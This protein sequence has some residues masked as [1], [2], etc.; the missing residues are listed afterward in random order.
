MKEIELKVL[1]INVRT[2]EKKLVALGAKEILPLTLIRDKSYNSPDGLLNKRSELLRLRQE[3]KNVYLTYKY[4]TKNKRRFL[5]NQELEILVS[6]FKKID[7]T[8]LR[9][10]FT[11][12]SFREKKRQSYKLDKVRIEIDKYP[13]IPAYIELEGSAK[14]I[15]TLLKKLDIDIRHTYTYT[16]PEV[17]KHYK[18]NKQIIKF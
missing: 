10:G 7:K 6:D 4:N 14:D 2:L 18:I 16:V 3:G 11:S 12:L 1:D 13:L 9:L 5:S 8:L 17:F 15:K